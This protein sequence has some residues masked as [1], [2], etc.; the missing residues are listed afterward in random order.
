MKLMETVFDVQ[1]FWRRLH[2]LP[3]WHER[4]GGDQADEPRTATEAGFDHQRDPRHE[5]VSA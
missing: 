5:A 1:S 2:G 4:L 3:G